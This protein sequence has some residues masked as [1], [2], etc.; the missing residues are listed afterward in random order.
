MERKYSLLEKVFLLI[1]YL[2]SYS[3][4]DEIIQSLVKFMIKDQFNIKSIL[5]ALI[6]LDFKFKKKI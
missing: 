5:Y 1:I 2:N 4:L 3:K 6:I